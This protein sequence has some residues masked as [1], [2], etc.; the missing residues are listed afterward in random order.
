M[1]SLREVMRG[2]LLV[3]TLGD[4]LRQF[5]MFITFP[6]FSLYVQALGGSVVDIGIV[7]S[8]R[9]LTALFLYPIAGYLSD[10][11]SRVKIITYSGLLS[12]ALWLFF[13]YA[14]DWRWLA[15]GNLFLGLMTFYFPAANSLMAD[16]LPED[17]RSLG[18]GMWQAIPMAAGIFS[19]LAG[20]YLIVRW[21]VEAAMRFLYCL[22][23]A[24]TVLIAAMNLRFLRETARDL[25]GT[26]LRPLNV[27]VKSYR[28]TLDVFRWLPGNLKAFGATLVLSFFFNSMVSSYWVVH[29]VNVMG[30]TEAQWGL[31]LFVSS[32]ANVLLLVPAGALVD[33]FNPKGMLT[34]A[35]LLAASPIMLFPYVESFSGII[36]LFLLI[37]LANSILMAGAPSY[38]A[39]STT[40]ETRGRI[41]SVLGQGMLLINVRGGSVGGPGMGA[42]LTVPTIAG[43]LIG[44]FVYAYCPTLLWASF[45]LSIILSAAL[46]WMY[47]T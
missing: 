26:N 11:Y 14:K 15:V 10:H 42:L 30:L 41:M 29:A 33:R 9:P 3:F 45:G 22:T 17:K 35:L 19:P 46:C 31:V 28:E 16:S 18:Y 40:P 6:Y 1:E 27:L 13:I 32:A 38:M 36:T 47:L 44:G 7:N 24:V 5:S 37:A 21:G 20:G 4:I 2:N 12:A 8:L 25:P 39:K 23:L 34:L 43:A